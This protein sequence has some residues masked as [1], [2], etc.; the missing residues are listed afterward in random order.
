[1]CIWNTEII[2]TTPSIT[3]D[4]GYS[5]N[6]HYVQ[7]HITLREL[8]DHLNTFLTIIFD[9]FFMVSWIFNKE[10]HGIVFHIKRYT[11]EI[12][13]DLFFLGVCLDFSFA[14]IFWDSPTS[15]VFPLKCWGESI[16]HGH[17]KRSV[18]LTF[19]TG[20]AITS[21]TIYCCS[22]FTLIHNLFP[23]G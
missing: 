6:F 18:P 16:L 14:S 17:G 12:S 3:F 4:Y 1:M 22:H 5:M 13:L 19:S 15:S 21:C 2:S 10:F 11:E 23:W 20:H 8:I 7:F 9:G